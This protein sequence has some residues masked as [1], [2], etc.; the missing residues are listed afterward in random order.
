M[1]VRDP[2]IDAYIAASAPFAQPIL[3]RLREVVHA[4]CPA[5]EETIK[6][7]FPHFMYHGILCSMAAFKRHAVFGFWKGELIEGIGAAG[8]HGDAMGQYGRLTSI[9]DLP[10]RRQLVAQVRQAMQLNEAGTPV[11]SRVRKSPRP[12]PPVPAGLAAALRG[13]AKARATF[14]G[15]SPS[16]RREYCE[17]IAEAKREETRARRVAEAVGWLRE[18]KPRNWKHMRHGA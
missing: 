13:D 14:E 1:A 12:A 16:H 5:V 8:A 2:R 17:W 7:G 4:A 3:A 18:G 11:P 9:A 15:F 10:S 6:W